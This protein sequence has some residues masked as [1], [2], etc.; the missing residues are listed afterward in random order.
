[1]SGYFY[2][3]LNDVFI[4][5]LFLD[6][7]IFLF[8]RRGLFEG[9]ITLFFLINYNPVKISN[10]IK[11]SIIFILSNIK[12]LIRLLNLKFFVFK[13]LFFNFVQEVYIKIS[14]FKRINFDKKG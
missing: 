11:F 7:L 5:S 13:F 14:Y 3:E 9:E 12:L 2:G 1:L 4:R 8:L 6:M 10:L